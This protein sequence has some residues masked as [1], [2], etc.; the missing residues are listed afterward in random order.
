MIKKSELLQL[1]K[2]VI[3]SRQA[4]YL[5]LWILSL[6]VF[7]LVLFASNFDF[8]STKEANFYI[9]VFLVDIGVGGI[10]FLLLLAS[11]IAKLFTKSGFFSSFAKLAMVGSITAGF[12]YLLINLP[13][14]ALY[15]A[16]QEKN[17]VNQPTATTNTL[18]GMANIKPSVT[19]ITPTSSPKVTNAK[20]L[21]TPKPSPNDGKINCVINEKCGGGSIRLT[22]E[23]CEMTT[24]CE[25]N[26][27]WSF[28]R[29]KAKCSV[30]QTTYYTNLYKVN[31]YTAP[32]PS[33]PPCEVYYPSL[34]YSQ[35]Y[36]YM[37]TEACNTAKRN[38]A[39]YSTTVINTPTPAPQIDY[40]YENSRCK[41]DVRDWLQSEQ[42]KLGNQLRALGAG[43][44]SAYEY[45]MQSLQ[46]QAERAIK[47][48]DHYYPI[49]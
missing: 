11:I 38:A 10:A 20:L 31:S 32:T 1:S 24:C 13:N 29:D 48:C 40:T 37:T 15:Q 41:A 46:K 23:E 2:R 9:L 47:D 35:T 44:S 17:N 25:I 30:D 14:T 43:D 7:Y 33:Y 34:G 21:V 27:S 39:S 49:Q 3:K 45:G 12:F 5:V 8:N 16:A 6:I 19:A 18:P 36:N 42:T 26:S 28:Y 22:K 4:N